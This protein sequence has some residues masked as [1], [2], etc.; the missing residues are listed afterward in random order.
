M[1]KV[2]GLG[3]KA[4]APALALDLVQAIYGRKIRLDSCKILIKKYLR[5]VACVARVAMWADLLG[6]LQEFLHFG[7]TC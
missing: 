6:F 7:V 1:T 2:L 5:F 3:I 4:P